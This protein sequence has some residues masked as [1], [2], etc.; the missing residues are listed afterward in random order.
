MLPSPDSPSIDLAELL[1]SVSDLDYAAWVAD[2]HRPK[3]DSGMVFAAKALAEGFADLNESLKVLIRVECLPEVSNVPR[4]LALVWRGRANVYQAHERFEESLDAARRA[5]GIYRRHGTSFDIAVASV[6]QVVVLGSMG[7]RYEEALALAREIR[8]YIGRG[9]NARLVLAHLALARA[10]AHTVALQ[11]D[12]ALLD[13]GRALRHFSKLTDNGSAI[14]LTLL[15][16]GILGNQMDRLDDAQSWL[17]EALATFEEEESAINLVK[18]FFALANN[19]WRRG[20]FQAALQYLTRARVVLE[21]LPDS[22]DNGFVD[23]ETAA[24]RWR[25]NQLEEAED[26]AR[27]ALARFDRLHRPLDAAE[28]LLLLARILARSDV[29][30]KLQEA[31]V[32]LQR[33]EHVLQAHD[34]P[35]FAAWVQLEKSELSLRM[36]LYDEASANAERARVVFLRENLVL[37]HAH[38]HLILGDA[39]WRWEPG[40]AERHYKAAMA[41]NS[42]LD[43]Q[44]EARAYRGLGRLATLA[45]QWGKAEAYFTRALRELERLRLQL[46]SHAHQAGF[47][48]DKRPLALE[49]FAAINA[50][51]AA[52]TI[53]PTQLAI[54]LERWKSV[55][56]ADLLAG[57][58][59]DTT[60]DVEAKALLSERE[61]LLNRF[62]ELQ[63]SGVRFGTSPRLFVRQGQ[64]QQPEDMIHNQELA[65]L[66]GRLQQVDETLASKQVPSLGWR[67]GV[68][69]DPSNIHRLLDADTLLVSY[70]SAA[71]PATFQEQ[72]PERLYALTATGKEGDLGIHELRAN[73]SEISTEWER[74]FALMAGFSEPS[75]FAGSRA[76]GLKNRFGR[77]YSFLVEPFRERL[78]G[79]KRLIILPEGDLTH[80]P[81]AALYDR[82]TGQYLVEQVVIQTAPSA[83]VLAGCQRHPISVSQP[84]LVGYPGEP[85]SVDYLPNAKT[86][87][88]AIAR[89][90]GSSTVLLGDQ[91]TLRNVWDMAPQCSLLHFAG[92][93]DFDQRFPL[94]SS[95]R[96]A[97]D[98]NLRASDLYL[99][100]GQFSG[101]SIV[102][103]ACSTGQVSSWGGDTLG[104]TSAFLYAG[105]SSIVAGLWPVSDDATAVLMKSLYCHLA[106]HK[107]MATALC[108]AQS[109]MLMSEQYS[110][111]FFWSAFLVCGDS[112]KI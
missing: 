72:G 27:Q 90:L 78:V 24:I 13:Y 11:L 53:P 49:L 35:V 22:P 17:L 37:S 33:A 18:A 75:A 83:T 84:L 54:W 5:V 71:M 26:L 36:N 59:P 81:F 4:N 112:R 2:P 103:G 63:R 64:V 58:P 9:R 100:F 94:E 89:I 61:Q 42:G 25:L 10:V 7:D 74:L 87:I 55:A 43:A 77:L 105:A 92:H 34:M 50:G 45:K 104:L 65:R 86:E 1:H 15:N 111:P 12:S 96:L 95:L 82:A 39:C 14:A 19:C 98:R 109:E 101:A 52:G 32:C 28:A 31:T 91:A 70:Y 110:S 66:R 106:Q 6:I 99:R 41:L 60:L 51:V 56:L 38:A 48:E 107:D 108:S 57:Q 80:I 44:L 102:L 73:A 88:E 8:P 40:E 67:Q 62:D 21:Q 85:G 16:M 76:A 93:A 68:S 69:I 23:L 79:K 47:F 3:F 29:P 20:E 46:R 30:E 97:E